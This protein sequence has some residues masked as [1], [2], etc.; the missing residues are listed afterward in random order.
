MHILSICWNAVAEEVGMSRHVL[1]Q[2]SGVSLATVNRLLAGGGME[3][4]SLGVVEAVAAAL[5]LKLRLEVE[6]ALQQHGVEDPP[7]GSEI[8][9]TRPDGPRHLGVGIAS[10]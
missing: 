1:A 9:G 10:L 7:S 5:D 3:R 4:T 6:T 2:R 8:A